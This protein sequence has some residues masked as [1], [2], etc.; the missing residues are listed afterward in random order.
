MQLTSQNEKQQDE[1]SSL[2]KI[3]NHQGK[4]LY[5]Y[6]FNDPLKDLKEENAF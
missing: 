5:E 2:K 3:I 1:I 6:E 4:G